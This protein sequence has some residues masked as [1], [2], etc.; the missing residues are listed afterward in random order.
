VEA[1]ASHP[2][3]L[4]V[5]LDGLPDDQRAALIAR[6]VDEREY[7]EIAKDLEC[8][9]LVVRKRVS[10]ALAALRSSFAKETES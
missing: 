3:D 1:A 5:L 4:D 10:R 9:E 8:S 6:V 2:P 7:E